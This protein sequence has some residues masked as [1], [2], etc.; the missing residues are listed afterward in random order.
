MTLGLARR[1]RP[2]DVRYGGGVTSL[3]LIRMVSRNQDYYGVLLPK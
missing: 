2:E 1:R 3:P